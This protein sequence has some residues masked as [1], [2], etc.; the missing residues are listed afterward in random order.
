MRSKVVC[1]LTS[2]VLLAVAGCSGGSSTPVA[3]T[4]TWTTPAS[5]VY[6]TALSSTQLDAS[7]SAPGTFTYSPAAGTVLKAGA[8]TLS[9]TFTPT[10]ASKYTSATGSVMLT[11]TQ[12]TPAITWTTPAGITYGTALSGAQLDATAS[13]AGTFVYSPV[14][15]QVPVAGNQSL[16]V[17]FTPTDA[18]DYTT[19]TGNVT[20]AVGKATPTVTWTA[21]T[22]IT[23]GTAL[24]ATQLDATASVPGT[25]VYS[26]AAGQIPVAGSQTLSVTFTPTDTT[27]YSALPAQTVQ[28]TVNMAAFNVTCPSAGMTFGSSVPG[29]PAVVTGEVTGDGIT[30]SCSTTATSSSPVGSYP[31]TGTLNDPNSKLSNYTVTNTLGTLT[32]SKATPVITWTTPVAVTLGATLGSTQLNATANVPGAFVY[33]PASGTVL[34]TMGP[35]QLSTTF[36]PT[37][38]VDYTAATDTVSLTVNPPG[39]TVD[40][41]TQKQLIRGFGGSTA[42]QGQMTTQQATA[43]FSPTSG[44]GLS[45]LRVRIDP[46]GK[47]G[48]GWVPLNGNWGQEATNGKEAVAANPN[49]IVFASPWTPPASMKI[50]STSEP[51]YSG[52]CSPAADYCGGYLDQTNYGAA[53]AAY[54]EDFV[55]YF[56]T[57]SGVK[58]YAISMQNEPDY[59]NVNYESCYWT[60]A[61]MDAWIAGNAS[62]LTANTTTPNTKF[63]MPESFQFRPA[64]ALTA[65]DDPNAENLISIIGGHIYGVS[66]AVYSFPTGV[67]PKELWMTEHYLNSAG[68]V[69]DALGI[70]EEVHASLVTGQYSAYVWWGMLGA[71]TDVGNPGLIDSSNTPTNFGYGIG[72]FSKFV[73]PGYFRY[74]ATDNPSG[75]VFVSAYGGTPNGMQHYVIVAI[76]ADTTA[77]NQPFT[78]QNG[79]VTTLT[80]YETSAT[81]TGGLVPQSA[82]TVSGNAFTY[83]LPAQSITTFVQ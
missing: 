73:Q 32:V 59:P 72:H 57:N 23:Y 44:L 15:G 79:T 80:P 41:G 45:V 68:D 25:F 46:T 36:T 35:V 40:F 48:N 50:S 12:A 70:A 28:L 5:I 34:N 30:A 66:P 26:P 18:T 56:N 27:D 22:A 19:A 58:L 55:T 47:V 4:V 20:L 3:P 6:G 64:Q 31:I 76:N 24:S 53:Y 51:Y 52:S 77:V 2:I 75:N 38:A 82:I 43:L 65:L 21:P 17:T 10:D 33:T 49:A 11:V 67:S 9:V 13:V 62:V 39:V 71:V 42:W 16:S 37:D 81:T 29:L 60:A 1:F 69:T 78:I 74:N 7:A 8:Q 63:M 14:A 54:L 83:T 61:Q